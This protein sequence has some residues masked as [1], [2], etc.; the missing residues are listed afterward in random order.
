MADS[1]LVRLSRVAIEGGSACSTGEVSWYACGLVE[2]G[3]GEN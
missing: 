3:W 2:S 1:R